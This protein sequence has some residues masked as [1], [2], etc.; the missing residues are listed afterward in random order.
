MRVESLHYY[1]VKGMRGCALTSAEVT[2]AG[3]INDRRWMLVDSDGRFISQREEPRLA[4]ISVAVEGRD[5]VA[6]APGMPELR[7]APLEAAGTL[8]VTIWDDR[9]PVYP[10][11]AEAHAWFSDF[12]GAHCRLVYQGDTI[13]GVDPRWSQ[14]GD[15]T[16]FADAY[17][18]LICTSASLDDLAKRMGASLPMD[19][20]RPNIVVAG[21]DSWAEDEWARLRIGNV[22]MDLTK[23]CAR[24]SVTTVD[25]MQGIR[26][27]KE[28]LRTLAGFRFLQVP[29]I[30]GVIF[31]Q[32]AIPRVFGRIA[33]GE[34]VLVTAP[35]PRPVFKQV[36]LADVV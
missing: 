28:P 5:L 29:G 25:Q 3:F 26:T 27:G 7:V 9:L 18:L 19:R 6:L 21:S 2:A 8:P 4:L 17:P 14:P 13:R 20:F 32:N 22:E 23:P 16:S 1:P 36:S 35:Q 12:L 31:G 30:S 34:E 15:I 11:P 33:V 24:C 10:A